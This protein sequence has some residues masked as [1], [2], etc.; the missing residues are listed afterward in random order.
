EPIACGLCPIYLYELLR[1]LPLSIDHGAGESGY[2]AH[3][4]HDPD[5]GIAQYREVIAEDLDDDLP[6]DLGNALQYVVPDRL[7]KA[8]LH[9]GH[10][11]E[12]SF[13]FI[14]YVMLRDLALPLRLGL[15][16]DVNLRH[17]DQLRIGAVFR[18]ARLVH[19]G[20][21]FGDVRNGLTDTRHLVS[22]FGD[23]RA[24]V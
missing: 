9:A 20:V 2:I 1:Q 14:D 10:A 6:V 4:A 3:R 17:A 24:G 5:S 23:R 11:I 8:R 21:D 22:R 7:R 15:Q 19:D 18:P 16:V 12:S 13:H